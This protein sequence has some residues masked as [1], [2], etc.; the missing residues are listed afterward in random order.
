VD[1]GFRTAA[2]DATVL[3]RRVHESNFGRTQADP[4][5]EYLE[6]LHR[7]LERRRSKT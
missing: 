5:R 2:I 3:L 7:V 1:G 6:M 4:G